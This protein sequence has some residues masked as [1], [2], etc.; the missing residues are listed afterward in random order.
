M[1]TNKN[2][3][4][5][6]K[7]LSS[8]SSSMMSLENGNW[9]EDNFANDQWNSDFTWALG[10]PEEACLDYQLL[11]SQRECAALKHQLQELRDETDQDY[12][13]LVTS[14]SKKRDEVLAQITALEQER[15]SLKT[16]TTL[17]QVHIDTLT[18]E[19]IE[20]KEESSQQ[21]QN[22]KTKTQNHLE[23]IQTAMNEFKGYFR[24]WTN[25][26]NTQ[27]EQLQH[28]YE[29]SG[30]VLI[31]ETAFETLEQIINGVAAMTSTSEER[32][33]IDDDLNVDEKELA[34]RKKREAS[35]ARMQASFLK[36]VVER[37]LPYWETSL[38][39]GS[40]ARIGQDLI[41]QLK[42][43]KKKQQGGELLSK[44]AIRL[45]NQALHLLAS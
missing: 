40:N 21:Q 42:R 4:E 45:S 30:D 10:V 43:Q 13:L 38:F 33:V 23:R 7:Q 39:G 6:K 37:K 18:Q 11:Q 28:E 17:Q 8:K 26:R 2:E 34:L 12:S 1:F 22:H 9:Q 25:Q 35:G 15:D 32:D 16:T 14:A 24:I 31:L 41:E 20:Y 19:L 5:N 27:E 36:E 44:E 29:E 3:Q